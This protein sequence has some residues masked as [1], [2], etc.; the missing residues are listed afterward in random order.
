MGDKISIENDRNETE[1]K[2]R[3]ELAAKESAKES[4][5]QGNSS[6]Y[7]KR[8]RRTNSQKANGLTDNHTHRSPERV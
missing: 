3:S 2:R 1:S 5:W 7:R 4:N 8:V 6:S